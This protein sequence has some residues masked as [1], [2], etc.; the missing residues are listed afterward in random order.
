MIK[1]PSVQN[2]YTLIYSGDPALVLP[3]D[4]VDRVRALDQARETGEWAPLLS[5]EPPTVFHVR[6]LSGEDME[7]WEGE[8]NRSRL[9]GL[10]SS[11]LMLRMALTSID[12]LNGIKIKHVKTSGR[13]LVD[14]AS[15]R[16]LHKE[17]G[18]LALLVIGELALQI[19]GRAAAQSLGPKS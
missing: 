14:D 19:M 16:E 13:R 15:W 6:N 4:E 3:A 5:G 18:T 2:E 17:L 8:R 12:N 9:G 7:W 1:P 11:A 10:E